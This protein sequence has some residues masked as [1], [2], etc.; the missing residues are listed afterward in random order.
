MTLLLVFATGTAVVDSGG[1]LDPLQLRGTARGSEVDRGPEVVL[2]RHACVDRP[3]ESAD[4]VS[5]D[6]DGGQ[7]E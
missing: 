3:S 6:D 4:D 2:S 1:I 7:D 5:I